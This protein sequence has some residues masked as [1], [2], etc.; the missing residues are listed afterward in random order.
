[1]RTVALQNLGCKVNSYEMDAMLQSLRQ[2]GY[3]IVPF[4]ERQTSIS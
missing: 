3:Q 2:R 4:D 1:M